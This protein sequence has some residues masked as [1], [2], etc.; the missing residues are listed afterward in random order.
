M[1]SNSRRAATTSFLTLGVGAAAVA[2]VLLAVNCAS[3]TTRDGFDAGGVGVG[4]GNGSSGSTGTPSGSSGGGIVGIGSSD[5]G[6][7]AMGPDGACAA[8]VSAA[9]IVPVVLVFMFDRSGSMSD[10]IGN[11]QT[12]WTALV[13]GLEAFFADPKSKGISAS[14]QFF[15]QTDECNV[16]AYASPLVPITPL[17]S[18]VFA[19][20][21]DAI[22]PTGET[23]TQ[24]ALQGALQY[25]SQE[26]SQ[27][28][29][30]RVAVV[31]VT[32]GE[33][34]GCSSSVPN[35]ASTAAASAPGI[36]TYVIGIGKQ[37]DL[38]RLATI[39][40]AGAT[41]QPFFVQP[42]A[43]GIDG[44]CGDAGCTAV[45]ME[46][47]FQNALAVI[48]GATISCDLQL[49]SAPT[50]Q[51]LDFGKVN[52]Q[53]TGSN[54]QAN[55]LFYNQSCAGNGLGWAYD[56]PQTPTRIQICPSSCATIQGDTLGATLDI[57]L[58][59]ATQTAQ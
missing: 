41:N 14:L 6:A 25:A 46:Q 52:V 1:G 30:A 59:C 2:S 12:K 27:N 15:M 13:P 7:P 23:P 45:A 18:S 50:N 33:P 53:Y 47:E 34:N 44:G 11:G 4:T 24:P 42:D 35:V 3:Q 58:G 17:P 54:G 10:S 48:R 39:A 21:I 8:T 9:K 19:Q 37:T 57:A 28:P 55:T 29:G 40:E 43:G 56:D 31:L 38:V 49:P 32:D 22:S 36:P 16:N 5:G 20:A 51:S 26:L